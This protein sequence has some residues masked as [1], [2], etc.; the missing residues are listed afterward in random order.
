M[1][2]AQKNHSLHGVNSAYSPIFSCLGFAHHFFQQPVKP[3]QHSI[4]SFRLI[5]MLPGVA[6]ILAQVLG[7]NTRE[8][9]Y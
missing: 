6:S 2:A 3:E 5:G 1:T 9:S 7:A 8:L 4:C